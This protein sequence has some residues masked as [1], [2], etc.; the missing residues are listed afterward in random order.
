MAIRKVLL[1]LDDSN[2]CTS[3]ARARITGNPSPPQQRTVGNPYVSDA[4]RRIRFS[5]PDSSDIIAL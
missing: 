4:S 1:P 5:E 3:N 2:S